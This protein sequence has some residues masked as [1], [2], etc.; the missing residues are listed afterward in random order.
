[1]LVETLRDTA[2]KIGLPGDAVRGYV[3]PDGKA[4]ARLLFEPNPRDSVREV[5]LD[6]ADAW[7]QYAGGTWFEGSFMFDPDKIRNPYSPRYQGLSQIQTWGTTHGDTL[8]ST[9]GNI[10]WPKLKALGYPRPKAYL[11]RVARTIDGS[12][13]FE[14]KDPPIERKRRGYR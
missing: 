7:G 3:Y 1:M 12:K 4:V 14:K 8:F 11:F 9:M 13:P 2:T 6:V 10:I 5:L